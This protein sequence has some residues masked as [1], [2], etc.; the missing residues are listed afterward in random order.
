MNDLMVIE[1]QK[2]REN[3][4]KDKVRE[5]ALN[6]I[7][8]YS[9]YEDYIE[10]NI[11][12]PELYGSNDFEEEDLADIVDSLI[13][14]DGKITSNLMM[15]AINEYNV[16]T[17]YTAIY[18]FRS[19]IGD[20][21]WLRVMEDRYGTIS[22]RPAEDLIEE[23]TEMAFVDTSEMLYRGMHVTHFPKIIR[24]C[25]DN[26]IELHI[27]EKEEISDILYFANILNTEYRLSRLLMP[28]IHK[29]VLCSPLKSVSGNRAFIMDDT[30]YV[31]RELMVG[32]A[33]SV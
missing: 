27:D 9:D 15:D 22:H 23:V 12:E 29:A 31:P 21:N 3:Y 1:A 4:G 24:F 17:I 33:S 14:W 18:S 11:I 30:L 6:K 7:M 20:D 5:I 13:A 10:S 28:S 8:N 2:K 25:A 19:N 16:E 32:G 26:N